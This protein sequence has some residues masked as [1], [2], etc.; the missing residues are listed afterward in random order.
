M[1]L[2]ISIHGGPFGGGKYRSGSEIS[3]RDLQGMDTPPIL[4]KG[5]Y[6]A[7]TSKG[8]KRMPNGVYT[9]T[10]QYSS[11]PYKHALINEDFGLI[12][13]V[14]PTAGNG[15]EM[16]YSTYLDKYIVVDSNSLKFYNDTFTE[17]LSMVTLYNSAVTYQAHY[18]Y[19]KYLV[20]L[21]TIGS[22]VYYTTVNLQ[23][24]TVVG[25]MGNA[26]YEIYSTRAS[27]SRLNKPWIHNGRI[28][29][30]TGGNN[31]IIGSLAL[32]DIAPV[33]LTAHSGYFYG[34]S[35]HVDGNRAVV[36]SSSPV[37]VNVY[38]TTTTTWTRIGQYSISYTA[39]FSYVNVDT[40]EIFTISNGV[41]TCFR[42][43]TGAV[44]Y[45]IT[46]SNGGPYQKQSTFV[47]GK[48]GAKIP[49]VSYLNSWMYLN[50]L[51]QNFKL[52]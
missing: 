25:N 26:L 19:D 1:N 44:L 27:I 51:S 38:D 2:D 50:V 52:L 20:V 43:S 23:T 42:L 13:E 21:F 48:K 8:F 41:I 32:D 40:D 12:A 35:V 7:N 17:L 24:M 30:K 49:W 4:S 11:N 15:S 16:I 46:P 29:F 37:A 18:E 3:Y 5:R 31:G 36:S 9:F 6:M 28:Y 45:T 34:D 14:S 10:Y 47:K 22:Y 33:E 39:D